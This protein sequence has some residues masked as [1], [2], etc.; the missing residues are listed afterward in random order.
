MP[1]VN[2]LGGAPAGKLDTAPHAPSA[3][4]KRVDALFVLLSTRARVLRVDEHRRAIEDLPPADYAA[5]TY[6]EKW[7]LGIRSLVVEKGLLSEAEI[8]ERVTALRGRQP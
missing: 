8:A 4:D 7:L 5:L 3:W 1:R 2:D 6:Y